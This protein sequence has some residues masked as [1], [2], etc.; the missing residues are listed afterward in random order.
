MHS[1]GWRHEKPG[2]HLRWD[3]VFIHAAGISW[4]SKAA[5]PECWKRCKG[6]FVAAA[7][8]FLSVQEP[9]SRF[10]IAKSPGV[11]DI[12]RPSKKR[13]IV[14]LTLQWES[15][16]SDCEIRLAIKGDNI[17]VIRWLQGKWQAKYRQYQMAG[18]A[19][20]TSLD[21][22]FAATLLLPAENGG[23]IFHHVYREENKEADA[24]AGAV[25]SDACIT[26]TIDVH[27][28]ELA[29]QGLIVSCNFDG[30]MRDGKGAGGWVIYAGKNASSL[31]RIVTGRFPI[32]DAPSATACELMA[33]AHLLNYLECWLVWKSTSGQAVY[34]C[35]EMTSVMQFPF[36]VF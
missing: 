29:P 17:A 6:E 26:P 16:K 15:L 20:L 34:R 23:E 25:H 4:K 2:G 27:I 35:A 33:A 24:L 12:A 14:S 3:R 8:K 21:K 32:S 18:R 11:A 31:Q 10:A 7:Y 1:E 22:M 5:D 28:A 36:I 30:S 19:C 13:K 9:E